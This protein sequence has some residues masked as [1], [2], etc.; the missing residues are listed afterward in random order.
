MPLPRDGW[1]MVSCNRKVAPPPWYFLAAWR[2]FE[3]ISEQPKQMGHPHIILKGGEGGYLQHKT[4]KFLQG[5]RPARPK[6][7]PRRVAGGSFKHAA[8]N[9]PAHALSVST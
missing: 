8:H 9:V 6:K 1:I 7:H 4:S 3:Y 5:L 2:P